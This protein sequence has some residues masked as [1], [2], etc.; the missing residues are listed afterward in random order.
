MTAYP[1]DD[2]GQL[3]HFMPE[4]SYGGRSR[5]RKRLSN[6]P[7]RH[8]DAEKKPKESARRLHL[9]HWAAC[10]GDSTTPSWPATSS[11]AR[12]SAGGPAGDRRIR[13]STSRAAAPCPP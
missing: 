6:W 12:S 3:E 9:L 1:S 13:A 5:L 7:Q 4:S 10:S 8:G 2:D 11:S